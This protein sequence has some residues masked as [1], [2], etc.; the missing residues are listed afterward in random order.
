MKSLPD[1][2]P[3]RPTAEGAL[4]ARSHAVLEELLSAFAEP[5]QA[6]AP[7]D[8]PPEVREAEEAS[9]AAGY[10]GQ[11]LL[12]AYHARVE[13]GSGGA[14]RAE[15]C[16]GL[17]RALVARTP[18][19]AGLFSGFTGIA[20][21]VQHAGAVLGRSAVT[22]DPL[23]T[24][25]QA[26]LQA[27]AAEVWPR[28]FDLMSGLVG[29]GVYV[30]ER[31]PREAARESLIRIVRTLE[32]RA[33][34]A[35]EGVTWRTP[36]GSIAPG[37]RIGPFDLGVAHGVPGVLA[38]LAA[39][40]AWNVESERA[41]RLAEETMRW[42][43]AQRRRAEDGAFAS[44]A[45]P[46]HDPRP[47][48]LAW[49]YGDAGIAAATLVAGRTFQRG[50]WQEHAVAIGRLAARR[51]LESSGVRDAG[52]CHGAAGLALVFMRLH[53]N[54]G[55]EVFAAAARSWLGVVLDQ[56]QPG[57]GIAGF[58]TL[59]PLP[60]GAPRWNTDPGLL[61][62]AAGVALALLAA[63]HPI[64]PE[65]DRILLLSARRPAP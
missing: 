35:Q 10:A 37:R 25:D 20:W 43:L 9:L 14:E 48:R 49:C 56:R 40:G 26:L 59:L 7:D 45:G 34:P 63:L 39:A 44:S 29:L 47:A 60:S 6:W 22:D 27:L 2:A 4:A 42:L 11:A 3:W 32:A 31:M 36:P 23:E 13:P 51:S 19:E 57:R 8:A 16:L 41:R 61:T 50:D 18:M 55:D 28:H 53:Q 46:G 54:V 52:L 24:I 15:R 58:E 21:T 33:E 1:A 65:W 12:H 30:L 62:G 64:E 5:R 38:L 17:A